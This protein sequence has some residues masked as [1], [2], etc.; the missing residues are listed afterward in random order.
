MNKNNYKM[1]EHRYLKRMDFQ[2]N[3]EKAIVIT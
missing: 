1:N 3:R 2:E